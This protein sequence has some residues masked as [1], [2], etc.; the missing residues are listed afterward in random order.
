MRLRKRA[1]WPVL[2][3]RYWVDPEYD[4]WECLPQAL[5]QEAE[6]MRTLWNQLVVAFTQR[7]TAYH[8]MVTN[9]SSQSGSPSSSTTI[10]VKPPSLA[11]RQLQQT[12]LQN[13]QEVSNA[14]PV[15][16]ANKQFVTTQFFAALARYFKKHGDPPRQHT[17][18]FREVHFQH[19]FTEG[20]LPIERI[21]G[22]SQRL[23]LA[24]VAPETFSPA[25]SQ[26]QQKRQARTTGTFQVNGCIVKFH[27]I[28]HRPL[29][30]GAYLKVAALVGRRIFPRGYHWS[31]TAGHPTPA[32][33]DWSLQLT[34][35]VPPLP[36]P[37][38]E[39][40][41]TAA[42]QVCCTLTDE[43][44]VCLAILTDASGREEA[45]LLPEAILASWHHKRA[46]QKQADQLLEITKRQLQE[47]PLAGQSPSTVQRFAHL[48]AARAPGLLRLLQAL[49]KERTADTAVQLLRH[50][51]SCST[52]LLREARGLEQRY[53]SHR[54]WFYHNLAFQLCHRYQQL[55]TTI[56]ETGTTHTQ[57]HPLATTGMD[58]IHLYHQLAA[59]AR[60]LS[61]LHQA[62]SK[63]GTTIKEGS[64]IAT[65]RTLPAVGTTRFQT[66]FSGD[67][68]ETIAQ[69]SSKVVSSQ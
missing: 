7:Q 45:L 50:W 2:V 54:D 60:F 34:L 23:C 57:E 61:F 17:G 19:R 36:L 47:L 24:H 12:F 21:F 33:W 53:L 14:S 69:S 41:G 4:T 32:R 16:W 13:T 62:A 58:R 55:V 46:L 39:H 48:K 63:T 20:G 26:R 1:N 68:A 38:Q 56:P 3:Y 40:K 67:K 11:L 30:S 29:P 66:Q 28:L 51:A 43:Q 5:Q 44:R 49:E 18:E 15:T 65:R 6:A 31:G 10:P 42:L 22:R 59:P 27:T 35:E 8:N 9:L 25:L 64:R 52:K 37:T